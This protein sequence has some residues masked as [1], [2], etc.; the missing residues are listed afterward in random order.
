MQIDNTIIEDYN[1][2]KS[3]LQ[4][5]VND[6]DK[7]ITKDLVVSENLYYKIKLS[8]SSYDR[9]NI[10]FFENNELMKEFDIF[11]LT[12]NETK[13]EKP[14]LSVSFDIKEEIKYDLSFK[15]LFNNFDKKQIFIIEE[16]FSFIKAITKNIEITDYDIF[17]S[18]FKDFDNE[19][20]IFKT[21]YKKMKENEKAYQDYLYSL[22]FEKIKTL[23]SKDDTIAN[24]MY[25]KAIS[26][27]YN[28][29]LEH[30][31]TIERNYDRIYFR[32]VQLEAKNNNKLSLMYK[33]SR[34]SKSSLKQELKKDIILFN[35]HILKSIKETIDKLNIEDLPLYDETNK[36]SKYGVCYNID[37][38]FNFFRKHIVA[39]EF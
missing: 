1:K 15:S 24:N 3:V 7:I 30:F 28:D 20:N 29:T 2:S 33:K 19:F 9:I 36:V 6:F 39:N 8:N 5:F 35:G 21:N 16:A 4:S 23:F 26:T 32:I 27:Y 10:L 37:T 11:E 34:I 17:S 38:F 31:V 22:T 14:L 18:L 13:N 25:E 12:K